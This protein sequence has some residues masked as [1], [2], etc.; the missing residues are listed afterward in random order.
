MPPLAKQVLT[1]IGGDV[2]AKY[3]TLIWRKAPPA[4]G[5]E[6]P[7]TFTRTGNGLYLAN[8]AVAGGLVVKTAASG[9]VRVEQLVDPVT[10][11]LQNYL[12]LEAAATNNCLQSQAMATGPWTPGLTTITNNTGT[13]PDGTHTAT[14]VIPTAVNGTHE[15]FQTI[16]STAG[17]FIA[18]SMFVQAVGSYTG[19]RL[20]C[21][22]GTNQ[23][24][25]MFNL[26]GVGTTPADVTV[27]TGTV[28][29]KAI[30]ALGGG[31]Y[32]CAVWGKVSLATTQIYCTV[33]PNGS[34]QSAYTGDGTSGL[35]CWGAQFERNGSA[36]LPPT[37]Y[38]ATT[39]VAVTRNVDAFTVPF[40]VTPANMAPAWFYG[41][42]IERG[43]SATPGTSPRVIALG[44]YPTGWVGL[45]GVN[46]VTGHYAFQH[47][48]PGPLS[49]V[50]DVTTGAVFGN[51]VELL[52]LLFPDGSTQIRAS[53]NGGPDIVAARSSAQTFNIVPARKLGIGN[54]AD[55]NASGL[56]LLSRV[57]VGLGSVGTIADV[58][59]I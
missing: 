18:V 45:F 2:L 29:G 22:D 47:S 10:L 52:G 7:Y 3:G 13:A 39:T 56:N 54:D 5:G 55:G 34:T 23:F 24:G 27:G 46:G 42:L 36:P 9:N 12:K 19:L 32:W 44:T 33:F 25:E 14:S 41:R 20:V 49:V 38:I 31:W 6:T 51:V 58:R 16:T 1:A 17:E 37:S 8:D 53:V 15:D 57:L 35:K 4:F 50:S 40:F 28:S 11:Q 48:E 43:D 21:F 59:N 30:I 26:S